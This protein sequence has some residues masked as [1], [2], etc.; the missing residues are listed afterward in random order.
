MERLS[1]IDEHAISVDASVAETWSALL[2][3]LCRDPA[4]PATVQVGKLDEAIPDQR[5]ALTGRHLCFA[6][7][8]LVFELDPESDSDGVRLRVR[9][10]AAFPG[11]RGRLF[12]AVAIGTGA[13]RFVVRRMLKRIA[14]AAHPHSAAV[15]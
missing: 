3:V 10:W 5:L 4:D 15:Q 13:H 11:A 8:R 14:A 2:R 12:R 7:Y 9:T 6:V 1:Y